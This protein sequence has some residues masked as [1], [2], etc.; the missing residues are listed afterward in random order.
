M[1][2]TDKQ[3]VAQIIGR[4][5]GLLQS[6]WKNSIVC[7]V[8]WTVGWTDLKQADKRI[9]GRSDDSNENATRT[10]GRKVRRTDDWSDG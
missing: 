5:D 1:K 7:A 2:G 6:T 10:N 9:V 8:W 4:A 3:S